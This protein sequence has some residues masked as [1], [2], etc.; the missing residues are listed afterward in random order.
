MAR[1]VDWESRIGRRLRLRDLHIFFAVLQAGSM[2]RAATNLR[3]AQPSVSRAISELESA[4]GVRL[5]ERTPRGVDL[6]DYG[7][8]LHKC[9]SAVF[10]DL[11]QGIKDI[12]FLSDPTRGE[13]RIGCPES[14]TS[15]ILPLIIQ[16]FSEKH[17]RVVFE[18][19]AG[20]AASALPKLRERSLDLLVE[21]FGR[22]ALSSD[23]NIN[24]LNIETLFEDRLVIAVGMN[25]PWARRRKIE[26]SELVHEQWILTEPNTWNYAIVAETF[27][28]RGLDM[29]RITIK[30]LSV[31]LRT[32][33]L[34]TGKFVAA[35]PHSILNLH[36]NRL[37]L[38]A[39]PIDL[40][41][42]PWPIVIV[43]L[44]NRSVSPV[45]KRFVDCA[46][47]VAKALAAQAQ[48]LMS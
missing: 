24:E 26:L 20:S 48:A 13:L 43:T 47:D 10:D 1:A 46:R 19:D 27:R 30:T 14:V 21:R 22:G 36:P 31:N 6:T 15:S 39:L 38:K 4:L 2:A 11:R 35:L 40:P 3:V 9:G 41:A 37:A 23:P 28:A 29:P 44:K 25:G 7:E 18:V 34:A 42:R 17:P 33:L 32:H 5:F 12:E 16:R 8:A 45:V